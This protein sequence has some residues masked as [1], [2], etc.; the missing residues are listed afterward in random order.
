[1][2]PIVR[3]MFT[4][5]G[6]KTT[7]LDLNYMNDSLNMPD[8]RTPRPVF[9]V[10]CSTVGAH[11]AECCLIELVPV[12]IDVDR[13][14]ELISKCW[15]DDGSM[16][17][18]HSDEKLVLKTQELVLFMEEGRELVPATGGGFSLRLTEEESVQ[19]VMDTPDTRA[20]IQKFLKATRVLVSKTRKE[21][22]Q[23][24]DDLEDAE[25]ARQDAEADK[26]EAE[27]YLAQL[28]QDQ[29]SSERTSHI[30]DRRGNPVQVM[31][32]L[33]ASPNLRSDYNQGQTVAGQRAQN[34]VATSQVTFLRYLLCQT[35]RFLFLK[36]SCSN[37][38][39]LR[40]CSHLL[41]HQLTCINQLG[42]PPF[43]Q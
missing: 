29:E 32:Q 22:L 28:R 38:Q 35:C 5:G 19:G 21:K 43:S 37:S 8:T 10:D 33:G 7:V 6:G 16:V 41:Y 4:L 18:S 12:T 36:Q 2:K 30:Q 9:C 42:P 14:T 34:S 31:N 13:T 40:T 20:K 11:T 15:M 23:Y 1:M 17:V 26:Q 3:V 25:R 39:S 27:H 24:Q